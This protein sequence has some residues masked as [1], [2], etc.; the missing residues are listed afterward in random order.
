M[1]PTVHAA[2]FAI[3]CA[4]QNPTI[5]MSALHTSTTIGMMSA[6]SVNTE[7]RGEAIRLFARAARAPSFLISHLNKIALLS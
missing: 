7:P 6:N 2:W 5:S 1:R 3:T 4:S